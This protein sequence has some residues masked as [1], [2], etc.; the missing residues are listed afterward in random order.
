VG[1]TDRRF[2][3][4]LAR[5]SASGKLLDVRLV[6]LGWSVGAVSRRADHALATLADPKRRELQLTTVVGRRIRAG[7]GERA[8][9]PESLV[10]LGGAMAPTA[11]GSIVAAYV[12]CARGSD[13]RPWLYLMGFDANGRPHDDP[14][15]IDVPVYESDLDVCAPGDNASGAY[16]ACFRLGLPANFALRTHRGR[17]WLAYTRLDPTDKQIQVVVSPL[18]ADLHPETT[19]V[20]DSAYSAVAKVRFLGEE[21]ILAVAVLRNGKSFIVDLAPLL[22]PGAGPRLP[23]LD[24]KSPPVRCPS[25]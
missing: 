18:D 12:T 8:Q 16:E 6:A 14:V 20:I 4:R 22:V 15:M 21:V 3:T 11:S 5:V 23:A 19:F 1:P 2:V 9:L 10:W 17:T 13:A 24:L 7:K 25:P